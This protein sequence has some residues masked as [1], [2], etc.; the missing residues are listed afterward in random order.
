MLA[1]EALARKEELAYAINKCAERTG[2][3]EKNNDELRAQASPVRNELHDLVNPENGI[4]Q[5]KQGRNETHIAAGQRKRRNSM[6]VLFFADMFGKIEQLAFGKVSGAH[7]VMAQRT[8]G[9]PADA[10]TG[11]KK[12]KGDERTCAAERSAPPDLFRHAVT[13]Q[14]KQ[15]EAG[16]YTDHPEYPHQ[17]FLWI[18]R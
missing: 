2:K 4:E 7:H 8:C 10:K 5:E 15:P 3:N 18:L 9:K 17:K 13:E 11:D 12:G 1:S 14:R 6:A 16:K